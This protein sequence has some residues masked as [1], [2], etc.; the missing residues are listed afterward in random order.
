M[1]LKKKKKNSHLK[2]TLCRLIVQ[3]WSENPADR[4]RFREIIDRLIYIQNRI[5]HKQRWKVCFLSKS[6]VTTVYCIFL[7]DNFVLLFLELESGY[8]IIIKNSLSNVNKDNLK[9]PLFLQTVGTLL[10]KVLV[11]CRISTI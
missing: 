10:S 4:P 5:A 7:Y 2:T 9:L 11:G 3:C 8:V 1:Y 6:L